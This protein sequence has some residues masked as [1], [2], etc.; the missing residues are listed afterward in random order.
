MDL[1]VDGLADGSCG[2]L[3]YPVGVFRWRVMSLRFRGEVAL[4]VML[5]GALCWRRKR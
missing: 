1:V 2:S 4:V 3:R 5:G